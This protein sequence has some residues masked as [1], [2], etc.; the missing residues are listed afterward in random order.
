VAAPPDSVDIAIN[1]FPHLEHPG[2]CHP[3]GRQLRSRELLQS[4][5]C[6]GLRNT[7]REVEVRGGGKAGDKGEEEDRW[8]VSRNPILCDLLLLPCSY[9]S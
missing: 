3:V 6:F 2:Q 8:P 5:Q 1:S 4:P 9:S 7:L